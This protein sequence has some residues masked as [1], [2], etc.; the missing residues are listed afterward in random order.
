MADVFVTDCVAAYAGH[1]P[2]C[3]SPVSPVSVLYRALCAPSLDIPV[4]TASFPSLA[5]NSFALFALYKLAFLA[6]IHN[7][8]STDALHL[9]KF[10][11]SSFADLFPDEYSSLKPLIPFLLFK[12]N[13]QLP[14][15]LS[16]QFQNSLLSI[17]KPRLIRQLLV[18]ELKHSRGY[19]SQLT[20]I[21][22]YLSLSHNMYYILY[23]NGQESP[24]QNLINKLLLPDRDPSISDTID[25][26]II[27]DDRDVHVLAQSAGISPY[28]AIAALQSVQLLSNST[29]CDTLVENTDHSTGDVKKVG[30][31]RLELAMKREV[32]KICFGYEAFDEI[33]L[34]FAF[35]RGIL[36][37]S[38]QTSY[39]TNLRDRLCQF[40]S[41]CAQMSTM[42]LQNFSPETRTKIPQIGILIKKISTFTEFESLPDKLRIGLLRLQILELCLLNVYCDIE[43]CER[44]FTWGTVV[45]PL[46]ELAKLEYN[47]IGELTVTLALK[48]ANFLTIDKNE[49]PS[50]PQQL[51]IIRSHATLIRDMLKIIVEGP[52]YTEL[53]PND[54][55]VV[56]LE[57]FLD[58]LLSMHC[59]L[60]KLK[61][62]PDVFARVFGL[63]KLMHPDFFVMFYDGALFGKIVGEVLP[64]F[65]SG[66]I[67]DD[68]NMHDTFMTNPELEGM[69]TE[70]ITPVVKFVME[71]VNCLKDDAIQFLLE[72]DNDPES[73]FRA[74]FGE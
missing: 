6:A 54:P 60:C 43:G 15:D 12:Q 51:E 19:D 38:V 20:L 47:G 37:D 68:K 28:E 64:N 58:D 29:S 3:W 24:Y 74:I 21:I 69:E 11:L 36:P 7:N 55:S 14:N 42:L 39:D 4:L 46:R 41:D 72:N 5:S 59:K 22:R 67:S 31:S 30:Y 18:N 23:A 10:N 57:T 2:P 44:E 49:L 25:S 16:L 17:N 62:E 56:K 8:D 9:L 27:V 26:T 66:K 40:S 35:Y 61:C 53:V 34:R 48:Y 65:K 13:S 1:C 70:E 63:D 45:F 32:E 52:L 33:V 71:I 50:E 73:V